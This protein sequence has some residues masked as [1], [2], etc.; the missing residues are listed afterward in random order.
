M[1][2]NAGSSPRRAGPSE[3][4]PRSSLRSSASSAITS[5]CASPRRGFS[6]G[7]AM[8]TAGSRRSAGRR[9]SRP[10]TPP[11]AS[12][13]SSASILQRRN[14][15]SGPEVSGEAVMQDTRNFIDFDDI[16]ENGPQSYHATFEIPAAELERDEVVGVG[17]ITIDV[18][19]E[20]G[21]GAGTYKADGN[22]QFTADYQCARCLEPYPIANNSPFHLTFAPRPE[23]AEEDEEIEVA[24]DELD[25]E[26]FSER[27]F[28]LKQLAAEQIELSIPMKPLCDEEC[29]GLC[30]E[31][32]ANRNRVTCACQGSVVDER[33]V[34]LQDIRVPWAKQNIVCG[35]T[36]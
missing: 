33:C 19:V 32:G 12:R 4:T 27:S 17:P 22:V 26:F 14:R 35:T 2:P 8:P 16:D 29:L 30:A 11:T 7:R 3:P 9:R 5:A 1:R 10:L 23:A 6:A 21:D 18:H 34:A 25:V 20:Q 36:I 15:I 28:P 31:C 13:S 24:P